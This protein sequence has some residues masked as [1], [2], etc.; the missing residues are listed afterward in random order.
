MIL[1]SIR[2]F[3]LILVLPLFAIAS[4]SSK[5]RSSENWN[6]D[7]VFEQQLL[8]IESDLEK[9]RFA[10]RTYE[11]LNVLVARAVSELQ[12][13]GFGAEAQY[14][15]S[16]WTGLIFSKDLGDHEP[17]VQW[18]STFYN[19]LEELLG[20]RVMRLT[21]LEDIKIFNHGIPVAFHP[22]GWHGDDWDIN[23]YRLHFV[24]LAGAITYWICNLA[25]SATAPPLVGHA[26]GP[27]SEIPRWAM[28]KYI[29]PK[30]SD[31]VYRKYRN[32]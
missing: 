18:L 8:S 22:N 27:L 17:L 1:S 2:A 32:E 6:P 26:C 14:W 23:E 7:Q 20:P 3:A 19:R 9:G 21:G 30:L 5:R 10:E 12:D 28:K 25:C 11:A 29:A 16:S 31:R 24:P 15:A 4:E 13:E